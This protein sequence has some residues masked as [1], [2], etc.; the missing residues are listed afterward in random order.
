[1]EMDGAARRR[2]ANRERVQKEQVYR[3]GFWHGVR[4][5]LGAVAVSWGV[6]V[7]VGAWGGNR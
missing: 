1:M 6:T 4:F 3:D 5:T 7:I 2:S